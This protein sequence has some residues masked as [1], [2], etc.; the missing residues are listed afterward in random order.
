MILTGLMAGRLSG[1]LLFDICGDGLHYVNSFYRIAV[2]D[3]E[4][5]DPDT[6]DPPARHRPDT[7]SAAHRD[8]APAFH[9][10]SGEADCPADNA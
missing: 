9:R 4:R 3:A 1:V 5:P 2:D 8:H 7:V 6:G 10:R